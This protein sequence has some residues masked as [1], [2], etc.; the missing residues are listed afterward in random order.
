M[1]R[2]TTLPPTALDPGEEVIWSGPA[3]HKRTDTYILLLSLIVTLVF[4]WL[5]WSGASPA[6]QAAPL[7]AAVIGTLF[8]LPPGGL[9]ALMAF[10]RANSA[11]VHLTSRRVFNVNRVGG[12]SPAAGFPYDFT[13]ACRKTDFG[14]FVDLDIPVTQVEDGYPNYYPIGGLAPDAAAELTATFQNLGASFD[15]EAT[16]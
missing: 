7:L 1:A 9:A 12:V 2:D 3:R 15:D 10:D 4:V 13:R 16:A 6:V 5:G 8:A 11:T 14:G